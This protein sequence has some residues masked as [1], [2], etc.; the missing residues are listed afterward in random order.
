VLAEGD[1]GRLGV[2]HSTARNLLSGANL[3]LEVPN[4]AAA[5]AKARQLALITPV[6]PPLSA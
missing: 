2:S 5:V 6:T 1:G 3:R 4:R